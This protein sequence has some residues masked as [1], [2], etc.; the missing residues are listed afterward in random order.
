MQVSTNASNASIVSG[1]SGTAG[2]IP[3][4][5]AQ[6]PPELVACD[7]WV[8]VD[9]R[10]KHPTDPGTGHPARPGD[11]RTCETFARADGYRRDHGDRFALGFDLTATPFAALDKD[12]GWDRAADAP[13]AATRTL[14]DRFPGTY[15]ERSN[16]GGGIHVLLRGA[17]PNGERGRN[18]RHLGLE[19]YSTKRIIVMTG[20]RLAGVPATIAP[21][22]PALDA[23]CAEVFPRPAPRARR[24]PCGPLPVPPDATFTDADTA[25]VVA[26]IRQRG[27]GNELWEGRWADCHGW[28][29][30]QSEAE[31][32]LVSLIAAHTRNHG[33][34]DRLMRL[35]RLPYVSPKRK[36]LDRPDYRERT[37]A[38]ALGE[39]DP[40]PLV[41]DFSDGQ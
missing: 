22:Q 26:C 25:F 30:S 33:E 23:L 3:L 39:D 21:H 38:R 16:S 28:Y 8:C 13:D 27:Y 7:R 29:E 1:E 40:A 35:S 6:L 18:N 31:F 37:I 17:M 11:L 24:G 12:G 10:T 34:I 2:L 32:G 14:L 20:A 41:V 19:G 36:W 4:D 15:A 9:R 5:Y